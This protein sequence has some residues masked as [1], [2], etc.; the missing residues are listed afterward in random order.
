MAVNG[1]VVMERRK[2]RWKIGRI[3]ICFLVGLLLLTG[4]VW[5]AWKRY[6]PRSYQEV[7]RQNWGIVLP[8]GCHLVYE[9]DSGASFHGDGER[10]HVF[11][12]PVEGEAA[13]PVEE[14]VTLED[15]RWINQ[16]LSGLSVDRAYYPELS[17]NVRLGRYAQGDGS[18]MYLLYDGTKGRLYVIESFL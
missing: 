6:G 7:I 3:G 13:L 2:G 5:K 8:K 12:C 1:E 18:R 11:S 15:E 16:I 17:E 14:T 9:T 10:Y 4:G